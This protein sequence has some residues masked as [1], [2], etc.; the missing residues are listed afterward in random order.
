MRFLEGGADTLGSEALV[1][2]GTAFLGGWI[3]FS[4]MGAVLQVCASQAYLGEE[5]DVG[6][7]VRRALPR[8]PLVLAAAVVRFVAMVFAFLFL[9][10]PVLYVV[11]LLFAVSP[12]IVLERGGLWTAI[13]RSAALSKGRKWHILNTLGLVAIIYYLLAFGVTFLASLFGSFILNTI[14]SAVVTVLVYPVVAITEAVLYYDARIQSE[15]LDIELMT[16]ALD[17]SPAPGVAG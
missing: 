9:I 16:G 12:V 10:F 14:T 4:L 5:V 17:A 7:A 1:S 13:R 2:M 6:D 3:T 11:A 8:V 15:G